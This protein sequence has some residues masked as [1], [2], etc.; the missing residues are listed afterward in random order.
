MWACPVARAAP[1]STLPGTSPR[2]RQ[3]VSAAQRSTRPEPW[4]S[5]AANVAYTARNWPT[6]ELIA[7][8]SNTSARRCQVALGL[9]ASVCHSCQAP[10]PGLPAT[11]NAL[12]NRAPR[13]LSGAIGK[14]GQAWMRARPASRV[15]C[16]S[17][18]PLRAC[19]SGCAGAAPTV[20]G[21][22][23]K[24][25]LLPSPI[26]ACAKLGKSPPLW[27]ANFG[28][29]RQQPRLFAKPSERGACHHGQ[30]RWR[31]GA[32]AADYACKGGS[33]PLRTSAKLAAQAGAANARASNHARPAKKLFIQ[34]PSAALVSKPRRSAKFNTSCARRTKG[35]SIICPCTT[36]TPC[37]CA[38]A[39]PTWR[40]TAWA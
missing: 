1:P 35:A 8:A 4:L 32:L 19:A 16:G 28:G 11:H 39:S 20:A 30:A 10:C 36:A 29:Q 27:A 23:S 14:S 6:N 26:T 33:W 38:A 25:A 22:S 37:L 7:P 3:P 15:N 21:V 17:G 9:L 34:R 12:P 18:V 24:K 40:T 5:A 13:A 2:R 31:T